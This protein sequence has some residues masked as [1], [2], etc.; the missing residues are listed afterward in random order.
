MKLYLEKRGCDFMEGEAAESDLQ[1]YRLF[2]EFIAKDGRRICGDITRGPVRQPFTTRSGGTDWKVVSNNGLYMHLQYENHTGCYGY[3]IDA[4][5]TPHYTSA[6]ALKVINAASAVQFDSIEI[7]DSLP[8]AA[9]EYTENALTLERAYLTADHAKMVEEVAQCIRENCHSW[10][11]GLH[12]DF[13]EMTADEYKQMTLLAFETA[14]RQYGVIDQEPEKKI[15]CAAFA[16]HH[17]TKHL[18]EE[19]SY[20]DPYADPEFLN[21]IKSFAPYY[22]GRYTESMTMDDCVQQELPTLTLDEFASRYNQR[23]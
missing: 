3:N 10:E 11:R 6:D 22:A 21:A 2:L 12:R 9:H 5:F 1:N 15:S 19:Q 16:W 13:R 17:L 8:A 7:V 23:P 14:A 20:I 4:G 18:F